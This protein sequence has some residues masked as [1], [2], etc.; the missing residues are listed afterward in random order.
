MEKLS[1]KNLQILSIILGFYHLPITYSL[2]ESDR[3]LMKNSRSPK[4]SSQNLRSPTH[5][6]K[7]IAIKQQTPDRPKH[8]LKISDRLLITR[9][10]SLPNDKLPIAQNIISKPVIAYSLLK[11]DRYQTT[12]S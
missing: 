2:L 3:S 12:N 8:H 7:A 4:P 11:S 6:W 9:K 5:S 1:A 10:R